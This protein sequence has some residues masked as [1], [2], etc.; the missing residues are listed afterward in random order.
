MNSNQVR[1]FGWLDSRVLYQRRFLLP[2]G[3]RFRLVTVDKDS[4]KDFI[5]VIDQR[6]SPMLMFAIASSDFHF[7]VWHWVVGSIFS[8]LMPLPTP[9]ESAAVRAN[10]LS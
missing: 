6:N 2:R 3:I 4:A 7:P 1:L 8:L 5:V 9:A 10:I